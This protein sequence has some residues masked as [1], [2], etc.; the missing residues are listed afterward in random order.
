M[1][2]ADEFVN[3]EKAKKKNKIN[4][5][6]SISLAKAYW[7][8]FV[9]VDRHNCNCWQ[10]RIR[11]E[12]FQILLNRKTNRLVLT[13][14]YKLIKMPKRNTYPFLEEWKIKK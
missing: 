4:S 10:C 8:L 13:T 14:S 1:F 5:L 2:A 11:D 12:C 7:Y 6:T 9:H 3:E